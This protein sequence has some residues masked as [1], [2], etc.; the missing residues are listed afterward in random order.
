MRRTYYR[1]FVY[2]TL[3]AVI[4]AL[5][6]LWQNSINAFPEIAS[7]RALPVIPFV[8]CIAMFNPETAGM[9]Y[10]LVAGLI[11]DISWSKITGFNALFLL[12]SCAVCGLLIRFLLTRTLLTALL[13]NFAV[14]FAYFLLYWLFFCQLAGIEDSAYCLFSAYLPMALYTW[15]FTIPLYLLVGFITGKFRT[16]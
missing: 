10:G 1:G 3:L 6:Y 11:M 9:A 13:L 14:C 2:H 12:V 15:A 16:E 7:L 4:C 8:I 5:L